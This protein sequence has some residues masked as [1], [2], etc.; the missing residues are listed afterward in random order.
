MPCF[1]RYILTL[2]VSLAVVPSLF[3]QTEKTNV[4][5]LL[6]IP[7]AE[8]SNR[9]VELATSLLED[10]NKNF[11]QKLY[12]SLITNDSSSVVITF[13]MASFVFYYPTG[14]AFLPESG[15]DMA[16]PDE[17][18]CTKDGISR[19]ATTN[20]VPGSVVRLLDTRKKNV[21]AEFDLLLGVAPLQRSQD[22]RYFRRTFRYV[23]KDGWKEH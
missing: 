13:H 23:Y 7:W 2:A 8:A 5:D 18:V 6:G 15:T 14:V 3:S 19:R 10:T 22:V 12:R 21:E 17:L 9:E 4:F 11:D 20:Q 16:N 1:M